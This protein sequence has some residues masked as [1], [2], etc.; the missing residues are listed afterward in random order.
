MKVEKTNIE[1]CLIITPDVYRDYRGEYVETYNMKN[2]DFVPKL[3]IEDDIS[4]SRKN[5]FRGLHG[6][7]NAW[8]LIQCLYGEFRFFVYDPEENEL[9]DIILSDINRKQVLVPPNC[10]NGHLVLSEKAIFSY[11]QTEYYDINNQ[12][13]VYIDEINEKFNLGLDIVQ[14]IR[15]E[16]DTKK[17]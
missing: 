13:Q 10:A 8:K 9:L 15:S 4:V 1:H 14:L 7:Y 5:V 3:F 2:Y 6:D 12:F 11:K 16:R 17:Q